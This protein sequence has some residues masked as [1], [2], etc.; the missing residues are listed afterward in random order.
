MARIATATAVLLGLLCAR[1]AR[2]LSAQSLRVPYQTFTSPT[3][4]R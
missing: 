4:S 2:R 3:A 1:P